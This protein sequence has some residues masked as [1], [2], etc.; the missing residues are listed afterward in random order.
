M[1][2]AVFLA[3]CDKEDDTENGNAV[4]GT[5]QEFTVTASIGNQAEIE[6]GQLAATKATNPGVKAYGQ[7]MV[8]EHTAAGAE[9]DSIAGSLNLS[10]PD[11]LDL[12]HKVLKAA[13]T[14]LSG[15]AFDST[16]IA[17]QVKD[18][19]KSIMV[20]EQEATYGAN[21]RLKNFATKHLP[22]LRMH[23]QKADS[24]RNV[25]K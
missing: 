21:A 16:Y 8:T 7:M 25:L 1:S 9:L 12:E 10:T 6:L 17:S 3:S 19:Q 4:N 15:K 2:S 20:F 13:L 14:A 11:T 23:L 24:L 22:H 18:H 5:D